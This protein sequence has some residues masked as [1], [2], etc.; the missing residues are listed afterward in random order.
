MVVTYYLD[1]AEDAIAGESVDEAA[2]ETAKDYLDSARDVIDAY[3]AEIESK[4]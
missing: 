2:I 4:T 1:L 3:K